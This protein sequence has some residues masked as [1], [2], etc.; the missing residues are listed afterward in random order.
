MGATDREKTTVIMQKLPRNS[1]I[2]RFL[3]ISSFHNPDG[4]PRCSIAGSNPF[5]ARAV[6]KIQQKISSDRLRSG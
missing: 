4:H 3:I 2:I 6:G 5:P 1:A